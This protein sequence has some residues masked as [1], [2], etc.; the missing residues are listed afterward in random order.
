[1]PL[2]STNPHSAVRQ[3][4]HEPCQRK[5]RKAAL[6]GSRCAQSRRSDRMG[7]SQAFD[8]PRYIEALDEELAQK[9]GVAPDLPH[10]TVVVVDDQHFIDAAGWPS[11]H[12]RW[13]GQ[14]PS[15]YLCI[16]MQE[17]GSPV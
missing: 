16:G 12:Q 2:H 4:A 11:E 13:M 10:L 3:G 8:M 5:L 15:K 6:S 1:M 17:V 7:I 14:V 9:V